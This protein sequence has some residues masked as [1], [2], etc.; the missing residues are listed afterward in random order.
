MKTI[1][2]VS[3]FAAALAFWALAPA[4][5]GA[6]GLLNTKR[7]SALLAGEAVAAAVQVCA[8]KKYT[9]SAVLVDNDG[10]QQAALRGDGTGPENIFIANDKAYTSVSFQ[11]DTAEIVARSQNAPAPSAFTKIP[12]L[13][14]AAGGVVI[15]VGDQVI[16]AIA[17]SGAPGGDNDALCAKAGLDKI[18][19]RLK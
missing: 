17:V 7:I 18:R 10:V 8:E 1:R 15:K 11:S 3:C 14:L 16:G 4:A 2:N 13:V 9:V 6:E 12:H 19:D 5:A